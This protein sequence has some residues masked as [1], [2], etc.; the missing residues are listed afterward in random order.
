MFRTRRLGERI[1]GAGIIRFQVWKLEGTKCWIQRIGLFRCVK[2]C[3]DCVGKE[4]FV[5][6][7]SNDKN[8]F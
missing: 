6:F 7:F 4:L 5:Y 2:G 3:W 8:D 1:V